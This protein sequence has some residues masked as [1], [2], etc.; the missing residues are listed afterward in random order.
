MAVLALGPE[1]TPLS[2]FCPAPFPDFCFDIW[3]SPSWKATIVVKVRTALWHFSLALKDFISVPG[4]C[5]FTSLGGFRP[6]DPLSQHPHRGGGAPRF[7]R[8]EPT[9]YFLDVFCSEERCR[10]KLIRVNPFGACVTYWF[11][12][13]STV[14]SAVLCWCWN[15][16]NCDLMVFAIQSKHCAFIFADLQFRKNQILCTVGTRMLVLTEFVNCYT[17]KVI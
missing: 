2:R 17:I 10:W 16:W 15:V 7:R 5:P 11:V 1:D 8:L 13:S 3:I 9:Q 14:I 4:L 6:A 12:I